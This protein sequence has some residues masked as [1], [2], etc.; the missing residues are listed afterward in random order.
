MR[1]KRYFQQYA[2]FEDELVRI[3]GLGSEQLSVVSEPVAD[4]RSEEKM[5]E[6]NRAS[7]VET[8]TERSGDVII[9]VKCP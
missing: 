1:Q 7:V 9:E 2:P 8:V 3:P 4:V 6:W 5:T